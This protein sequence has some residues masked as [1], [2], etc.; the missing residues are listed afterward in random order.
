MATLPAA[1][2]I[3]LV[4]RAYAGESGSDR[5]WLYKADY[6]RRIDRYIDFFGTGVRREFG[7]PLRREL[8]TDLALG[9]LA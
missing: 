8:I 9:S 4:A 6:V 7:A 1:Q 2:S 5:A 3:S